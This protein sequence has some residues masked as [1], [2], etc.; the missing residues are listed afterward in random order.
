M[1]RNDATAA[2][3]RFL[4]RHNI[5]SW[6]YEHGG[7]HPRVAVSHAGR[8]IFVSFSSTTCNRNAGYDA[9]ARLRRALGLVGKGAA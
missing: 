9:V 1:K 8:T 3:E 5:T 2:I 7:K 6:H 4:E